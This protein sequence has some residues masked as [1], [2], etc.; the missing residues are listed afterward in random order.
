MLWKVAD[1]HSP[2]PPHL[3]S[4]VVG[5]A[6]REGDGGRWLDCGDGVALLGEGKQ[7]SYLCRAVGLGVGQLC[8]ELLDAGSVRLLSLLPPAGQGDVEVIGEGLQ[9]SADHVQAV[10][11]QLTVREGGRRGGMREERGQG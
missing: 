11:E 7:L 4:L 9:E 10:G 2:L 8:L 1:F 3:Y 5:Q 6:L